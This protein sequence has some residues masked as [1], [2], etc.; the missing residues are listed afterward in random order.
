MIYRV[1]GVLLEKT[2]GKAVVE[3]GNIA[4]ECFISINTFSKLPDIGEQVSLFTH[5]IIKEEVVALYGFENIEE[6]KVFLLLN[7]V[8]KVGPKLALSI[9][10]GIE[11]SELKE[12]IA[13]KNILKLS[14]IPGIGK[15][16][17][18]RIILELKDSFVAEKVDSGQMYDNNAYDDVLSALVNLGYKK[19]DCINIIKKVGKPDSSFEELLKNSLKELAK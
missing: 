5:L 17:A 11:F 18:E 15:K 16:T 13:S 1:K 6:K 9:L 8:S 3:T 14:S 2:P 4:V 7:K 19:A 10:S 12:V